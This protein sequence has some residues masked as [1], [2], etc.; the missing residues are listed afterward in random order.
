MRH[1]L[2]PWERGVRFDRGVLVGEVGPG[3]HRLPMRAELH[4]VDIRP[5]TLTPAAQDVPTA[6]GVLVRVTVVVRW[7]VSSPTKF[8]VE[9]ASPEEELYTAVQLALRGAVLTRAHSAVDTERAAIAAEVL[10][11]V[12]ARAEEL[13]VSVAEVAVRDVVMPA[14]LRRAALAELVAASEGRAALERARGE[15][16]ALRSLL[17][18]ARLAEEHPALLELRALQTAGTVVVDRSK[19]A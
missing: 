16:A 2:Y 17:N 4:R 1:T 13:G 11:G 12:A 15:T 19:R 3:R 14:E 8:V 7:V 6:D 9:S 18:A 5:R 10:A